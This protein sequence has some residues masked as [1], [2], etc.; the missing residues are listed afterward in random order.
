VVG[1]PI[2]T[3]DDPKAVIEEMLTEMA[4]AERKPSQEDSFTLE[5]HITM[6]EWGILLE[7]IGAIYRQKA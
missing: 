3:A 7:H 6:S 4:Q 5:R 1:R 2:L